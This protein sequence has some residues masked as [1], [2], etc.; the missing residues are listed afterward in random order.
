VTKQNKGIYAD[1]KSLRSKISKWHVENGATRKQTATH[2][3]VSESLVNKALGEH[4][5]RYVI[6]YE[7]GNNLRSAHISKCV[8][9]ILQLGYEYDIASSTKRKAYKELEQ[10]L[11]AYKESLERSGK[12][13][14]NFFRSKGYLTRLAETGLGSTIGSKAT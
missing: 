6:P 10:F 3:N 13:D 1:C 2:F 12:V 14:E 9:I 5:H 11:V 4:D 7:V 8:N